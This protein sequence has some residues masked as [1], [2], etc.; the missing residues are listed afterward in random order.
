MEKRI[1]YNILKITSLIF[2][3]FITLSLTACGTTGADSD[4]QIQTVPEIDF[5]YNIIKT[6]YNVSDVTAPMMYFNCEFILPYNFEYTPASED[7]LRLINKEYNV[8]QQSNILGKQMVNFIDI[9]CNSKGDILS[10]ETFTKELFA[11]NIDS[12]NE[13][14]MNHNNTAVESANK[15][16]SKE[17]YQI[18]NQN[19]DIRYYK[20]DENQK[21]AALSSDLVVMQDSKD[22][23][24]EIHTIYYYR[25]DLPNTYVAVGTNEKIDPAQHYGIHVINLLKITEKFEFCE[26][27]T[28]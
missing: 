24:I 28:I 8:V 16:Y 9:H 21:I 20:S 3:I 22:E 2:S 27:T 11:E 10:N 7:V 12:V 17:K 18:L 1:S 26:R 14:Y 6:E 4:N 25:E 15:F 23:S 5:D 19:V 13:Y